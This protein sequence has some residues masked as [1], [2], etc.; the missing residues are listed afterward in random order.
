[1]E[2]QSKENEIMEK[3]EDN[4]APEG[5]HFLQ[6]IAVFGLISFGLVVR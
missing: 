3:Y 1:M 5:Y 4:N 6:A 2:E